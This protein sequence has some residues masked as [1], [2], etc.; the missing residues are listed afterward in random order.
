[1]GLT[2]PPPP[3]VSLSSTPVSLSPASPPLFLSIP[4]L[5]LFPSSFLS[6]PLFPSFSLFLPSPSFFLHPPPF[7]PPPISFY[8]T[9]LPPLSHPFP[10]LE[11]LGHI[12]QKSY[13]C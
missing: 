10:L 2:L 12:Q 7:L 13:Q 9:F 11:T 8:F 6:S 4:I 1:M 5:S 3:T